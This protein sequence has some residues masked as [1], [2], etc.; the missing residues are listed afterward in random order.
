LAY[1]LR[2][3]RIGAFNPRRYRRPDAGP[4]GVFFDE[5][6]VGLGKIPP[7]PGRHLAIGDFTH[8]LRPG[9][10]T[11][12]AATIHALERIVVSID[13]KSMR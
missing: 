8:G 6:I 10:Q 1:P 3:V 13:V 7:N 11:T 4:N 9:Y 5:L 12:L 2:S